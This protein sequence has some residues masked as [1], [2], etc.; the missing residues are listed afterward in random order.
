[1]PAEPRRL[2][3]ERLPGAMLKLV[4]PLLFLVLTLSPEA[5]SRAVNEH[6]FQRRFADRDGLNLSREGLRQFGNEAVPMLALQPDSGILI[7]VADDGRVN[8]EPR[9]DSSC[10]FAGIARC[11]EPDNVS[12]DF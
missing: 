4:S 3:L 9:G 5:V 11:F 7:I 12:T 1:M 8:R 6:I 10:Q 2:T